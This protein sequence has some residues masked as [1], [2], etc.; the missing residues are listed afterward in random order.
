MQQPT[1]YIKSN[2]E[3][4]LNIKSKNLLGYL[5]NFIDVNYPLLCCLNIELSNLNTKLPLTLLSFTNKLSYMKMK[6]IDLGKDDEFANENI[7]FHF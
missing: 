4:E 3:K 6:M 5:I 7:Q 1:T 2:W